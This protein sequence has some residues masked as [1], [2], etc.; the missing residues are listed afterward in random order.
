MSVARAK[1]PPHAAVVVACLV[2]IGLVA[3]CGDDPVPGP[4]VLTATVE[5]PNGAEG[6]A[7][8]ELVGKGIV[9]VS[10]I[11]GRVFGEQHGDT[12]VVV[13]VNEEGGP[14][15]FALEVAD[16]TRRPI[17]TLHEVA[18]PDDQLRGLSGYT[19]DIRR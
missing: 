1:R 9:E 16:T 2:S 17:A 8:I 6:A 5:S 7:L 15:R 19:V 11:D 12:M 10:P 14:L 18:G 3:G 13:V 4:G